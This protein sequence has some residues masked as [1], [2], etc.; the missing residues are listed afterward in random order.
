MKVQ[1][2]FERAL[3]SVTGG[4]IDWMKRVGAGTDYNSDDI[5]PEETERIKKKIE[6]FIRG[7]RIKIY[8]AVEFVDD[9]ITSLNR[10][11]VLGTSWTYDLGAAKVYRS[12]G[13]GDEYIIEAEIKE[14]FINWDDTIALNSIRVR[15]DYEREIRLFKGTP[16]KIKRI[17]K[18]EG[19]ALQEVDISEIKSKRF[20][21]R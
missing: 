6:K 8:R 10:K 13:H 1:D 17:Y 11:P 2:L 5:N 20:K 7:G 9:P 19:N 15:G 4:D 21:T 16:I 3:S 14:K 18:V 12:H